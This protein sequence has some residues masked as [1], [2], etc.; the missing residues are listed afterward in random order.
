MRL[1][2]SSSSS[3]F[4]FDLHAQAG[5]RLV[6]QVDRLVGQETVGDVPVGQRRGRDDGGVGDAD[7]VMQLILLLQAAQDRD[8]ILD[9][10][11]GDEHR[12]ETPRQRRVLLDVLAVFVER[13][14]SDAMELAARQGGLEQVR[15]VHRA[16]GLPGAD[17]GVHLVDEQDDAALG[18]GHFVQDG[19]QPLLELAAVFR[20]GDQRPHVE[21]EQLL[22]ADGFGH[23]AVDDAQRESLD[24]RR[25]ADAGLADEDRIVLGPARQHLDRAADLL[26]AADDRVELARPRRLGEVAGVFL[27]RVIGVLGARRVGRAALAQVVDRGVQGLRRYAGVGQDLACLGPLL[28][29]Q[30]QQ[31]PLDGDEGIAGLLGDLFR[32][33]ENA[34]RGRGQIEL[35]RAGTLHLGEFRQRQFDQP[36]RLARI[37]AGLVDQAGAEPFFVVQQDLQDVLGRELLMALAKRERL[38][39][40]HETARPFG[41]LFKIH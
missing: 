25:L 10:R 2:N 39:G 41:V 36:Q 20:P 24:D 11:L 13:G 34:R 3:G 27:Q 37:A 21:R 16:L 38:G 28:H 32:V 4:E 1:S 33:V 22:V 17:E 8:R 26:V 18:G 30:R 12:L 40:L 31:Q 35:P 9:G 19:L 5:G 7:A 29:R 6:D 14:R 23:V 15:G